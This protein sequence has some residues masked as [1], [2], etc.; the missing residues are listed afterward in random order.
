MAIEILRYSSKGKTVRAWKQDQGGQEGYMVGYKE[1][2][3]PF[4]MPTHA[5]NEIFVLEQVKE[6]IA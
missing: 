2:V 4:W 3:Y 6:A 1:G 5:F